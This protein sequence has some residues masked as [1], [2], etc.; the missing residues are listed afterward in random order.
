[1]KHSARN[2]PLIFTSVKE[3]I[4]SPAFVCLYVFNRITKIIDQICMKFCRTVEHNP[5]TNQLDSEL[6][7]R[8]KLF[9]FANNFVQNCRRESRQRL[10]VACSIL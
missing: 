3:V 6:H 1:M 8:S 7:K 2:A 5:E 9:F 4:F 10:D